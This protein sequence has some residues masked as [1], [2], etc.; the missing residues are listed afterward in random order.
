MRASSS[1]PLLALLL[2][3]VPLSGC[4]HFR[5]SRDTRFEPIPE[6]E[7]TRLTAHE[8]GLAQCLTSFG[9]P[10]WVWEQPENG[11]DGAVLAYGW[12]DE[13][14]YG[15]NLSVPIPREFSTSLDYSRVDR[16][17]HGLVLFFDADWKLASWR[18]GL[19]RDLTR[20]LRRPPA[21]VEEES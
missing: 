17:M 5:W 8:T 2:A 13:H 18:V 9:A 3:C 19:L 20:E 12:F 7:L 15:M 4:L 21:S 1:L 16:R 6:A 11:H 14:D 10:L